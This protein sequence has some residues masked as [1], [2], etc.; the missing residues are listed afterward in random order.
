MTSRSA[1]SRGCARLGRT[2]RIRSRSP[3]RCGRRSARARSRAPSLSAPPPRAV[4]VPVRAC[5][6]GPCFRVPAAVAVK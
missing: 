2:L 5:P 1:S 6:S 3:R 4:S